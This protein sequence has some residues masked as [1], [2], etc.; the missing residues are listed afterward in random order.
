[1]PIQPDV[2]VCA[3]GDSLVRFRPIMMTTMAAMMSTLLHY[4]LNKRSSIQSET[5]A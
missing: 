4:L 5:A 2:T 3:V 1:V